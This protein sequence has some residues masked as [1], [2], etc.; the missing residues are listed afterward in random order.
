MLSMG[1]VPPESS[2]ITN[3]TG[4]RQ[5]SELTHRSGDRAKHNAERRDREDIKA[6]AAEKQQGRSGS[7]YLQPPLYY[8]HQR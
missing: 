7:R 2:I 8:E 5:Q 1:V 3:S 6:R 4:D